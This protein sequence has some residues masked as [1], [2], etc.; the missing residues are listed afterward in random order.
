MTRQ[1]EMRDGTVVTADLKP[2]QGICLTCGSVYAYGYPAPQHKC[3]LCQCE[4]TLPRH[5][6]SPHYASHYA[7]SKLPDLRVIAMREYPELRG[8]DG[9][10]PWKGS[11]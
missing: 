2:G 9:R 4:G 11:S 10:Q 5:M 3:A 8:A 1:Y 6:Q 7:E